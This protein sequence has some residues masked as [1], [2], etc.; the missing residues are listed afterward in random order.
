VPEE[1]RRAETDIVRAYH[2]ALA[3]A[4]IGGYPWDRCWDDY[5]RGA[6]AGF[7]VT[8]IASMIVQQTPRGDEMFTTMARRHA[9]TPSIS[10]RAISD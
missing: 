1:R 10:V 5:R 6:F 3:A 4:G 7:S 2:G 8:V 9:D